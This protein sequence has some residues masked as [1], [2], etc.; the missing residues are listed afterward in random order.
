MNGDKSAYSI[1]SRRLFVSKNAVKDQGV[2][3]AYQQQCLD[4]S[5]QQR[6]RQEPKSIDFMTGAYDLGTE[7]V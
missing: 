3:I 2:S 1:R 5:E 7:A 6:L 4:E